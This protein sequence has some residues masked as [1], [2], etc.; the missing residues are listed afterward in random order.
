MNNASIET[1]ERPIKEKYRKNKNQYKIVEVFN[2]NGEDIKNTLERIFKTYS[3]EE[4][5]KIIK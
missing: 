1:S 4:L 3:K 5:K 2:T